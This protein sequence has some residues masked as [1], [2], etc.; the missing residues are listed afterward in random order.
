MLGKFIRLFL[1]LLMP[2]LFSLPHSAK[3]QNYPDGKDSLIYESLND[4]IDIVSNFYDFT[5]SLEFLFSGDSS[6]VDYEDILLEHPSDSLYLSWDNESTHYPKIDL[7]NKADT[8]ILVLADK[9]KHLFSNPVDG[10][11]TSQFGMRRY[12]YH[13]GTDVNLATGDSVRCAFDGKIRVKKRSRSYGYVVV[14]RHLNG[15]ETLYAHLSK[16]LVDTNQEVKAGEIIALGGNTGRSHGS[17][18]HFETRYLGSPINPEQIINFS[19]RKLIS[20]TLYLTKNYFNYRKSIESIKNAKYYKVKSG[21]TL[22]GIAAK[23]RTSA[24][25]LRKINR[26]GKNSLIRAG[27]RIRVR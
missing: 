14:V 2:I 4:S 27:K 10:L 5:D 21:D 12:R 23:F 11:V 19:E 3:A 15:L 9:I 7:S 6:L 18:L 1:L 26:L 16:I 25:N 24:S 22:S 8:T 17:H 13:Y 20:D